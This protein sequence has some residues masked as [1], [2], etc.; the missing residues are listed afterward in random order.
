M[1]SPSRNVP[2]LLTDTASRGCLVFSQGMG[3]G[4]RPVRRVRIQSRGAG[5]RG[6]S[7]AYRSRRERTLTAA[8]LCRAYAEAPEE[9]M[10]S[11]AGRSGQAVWVG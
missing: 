1:L 10:S 7:T 11:G 3:P 4:P 5:L 6:H 2:R 8:W 9:A